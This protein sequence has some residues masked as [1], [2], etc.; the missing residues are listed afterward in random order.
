MVLTLLTSQFDKSQLN[1]LQLSNIIFIFTTLL[2]SHS[3]I[4]I[5]SISLY[6]INNEFI[7]SILDTSMQLRFVS[8]ELI[9]LFNNS[10]NSNLVFGVYSILVLLK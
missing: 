1:F 7:F 8:P 4:S 3:D 9:N 6:F 5:L 2:T 10:V